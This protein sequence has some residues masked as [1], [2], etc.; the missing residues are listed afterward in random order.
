MGSAGIIVSM[1]SAVS[2][3]I[4]EMMTTNSTKDSSGFRDIEFTVVQ[5]ST[6]KKQQSQRGVTQ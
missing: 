3:I 1:E 4:N 5:P 2:D 6:Y